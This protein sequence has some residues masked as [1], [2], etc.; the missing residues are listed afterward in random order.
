LNWKLAKEIYYGL[1]DIQ[2]AWL[3]YIVEHKQK[4]DEREARRNR[5][6]E[7]VYGPSRGRR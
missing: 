5:T 1:T 2:C 3:S 7:S 6:R 4:D